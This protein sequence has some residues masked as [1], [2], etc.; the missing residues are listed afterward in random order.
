MINLPSLLASEKLQANKANYPTFKVLIEEHA[1]SKGLSGYLDGSITK[2]GIITVPPGTA[3]TDVPTPV[4]STTPSRDE[5]T[6]RDSV[7]KSLIVTNVT[8]PIG[9]GLKRDGTAKECWDSV[10][11]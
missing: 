6:Y 8:D 9:L 4:F 7:L 1:A 10:T 5:W 2:P 3:S 11:T